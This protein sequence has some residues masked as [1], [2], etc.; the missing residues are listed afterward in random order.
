MESQLQTVFIWV[1]VMS[2]LL[3]QWF[4]ITFLVHSAKQEFIM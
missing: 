1:Q 2:H 3:L 4:R